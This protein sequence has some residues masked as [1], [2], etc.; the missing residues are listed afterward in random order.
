MSSSPEILVCRPGQDWLDRACGLFRDITTQTIQAQG[1]CVIALSGGTTPKA[2]YGAL[3]SPE[4]KTQCQWDRMIFLFGDE[5]GVPPDHPDSN[6][7]LALEALFRPL[8]IGLSQVHRMKG[9]STDLSLAAAD[10]EQALRALTHSPPPAIP[11][12][13]LVLLGLGEDGHTA[14]LFPGTPALSERSH[15][16]AVGL[17]PKGIPSRLTLTLGVINRAT[18][19]LFLVTGTGKAEMVRAVLQSKTQP[20]RTLPAA[21]VKPDSGHLVWLLDDAAAGALMR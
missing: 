14:S 9:E 12:L 15:L 20:E 3:T 6:Y 13:D 4:W 17:S 7:G 21:Q 16:V 10:Y 8:G 5:R 19:V 18:V 1:S 11:R 2:L